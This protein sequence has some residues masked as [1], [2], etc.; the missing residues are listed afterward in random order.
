MHGKGQ[1]TFGGVAFA[2]VTGS[3]TMD[4][5]H[6]WSFSGY[7]GEI[8][9]PNVGYGNFE[10]EFPG[11][12]HIEGKCALEIV[13]GGI[14]PGGAQITWFDLHGQIGTVIGYVFGGGADFGMGGGTWSETSVD[15]SGDQEEQLAQA[16]AALKKH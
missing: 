4:D 15:L 13:D 5:G 7:I 10:G 9:T 8:G 12:D 1:I 6:V 2:A 3:I 11:Y 14:G 16:V